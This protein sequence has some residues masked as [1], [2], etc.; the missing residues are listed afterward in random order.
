[1]K[2]LGGVISVIGFWGLVGLKYYYPTYAELLGLVLMVFVVT[3][4]VFW[5]GTLFCNEIIKTLKCRKGRKK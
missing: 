3:I 5:V 1:M 4:L 2:Y